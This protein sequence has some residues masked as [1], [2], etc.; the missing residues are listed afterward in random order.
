MHSNMKYWT[1]FLSFFFP[2]LTIYRFP[3]LN[4]Y[5]T[6]ETPPPLQ[7]RPVTYAN[8]LR[9]L[10]I[11]DTSGVGGQCRRAGNGLEIDRWVVRSAEPLKLHI[12]VSVVIGN[13]SCVINIG[14]IRQISRGSQA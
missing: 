13:V 10:C 8:M 7:V 4:K 11:A 2:N 5:S 9:Y 14:H 3:L 1:G 6:L 12:L